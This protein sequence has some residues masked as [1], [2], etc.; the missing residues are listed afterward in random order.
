MIGQIVLGC[1]GVSH[2]VVFHD[3]PTQPN[4]TQKVIHK[5]SDQQLSQIFGMAC[6]SWMLRWAK[7]SMSGANNDRCRHASC[8]FEFM[9][10]TALLDQP[11]CAT[12]GNRNTECGRTPN[13]STQGCRGERLAFN[14][15][16]FPV[17]DNMI[18]LYRLWAAGSAFLLFYSD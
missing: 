15:I 8:S 2:L 12:R 17:G 14:R 6:L 7:R 18:S 3:R 13:Q 10:N 16:P 4:V 5:T 11:Y 1:C 9:G